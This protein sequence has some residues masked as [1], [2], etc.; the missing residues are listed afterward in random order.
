[1]TSDFVS[2]GKW[3]L[4]IG[5]W[6]LESRGIANWSLLLPIANLQSPISNF[7]KTETHEQ[8]S[9]HHRHGGGHAAGAERPRDVRG[10]ARGQERRRA[11]LPFRRLDL[12]DEVR[13]PGEGLR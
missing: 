10:P 11:D 2:L 3:R 13:L 7:L 1:M 8:T 6:K 12:P 9:R 5:N 4:E